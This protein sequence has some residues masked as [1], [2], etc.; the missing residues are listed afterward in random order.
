MND[1]YVLVDHNQKMIIDHIKKLP[2]NWNNINGLNLLDPE[3]LYN[4]DWAGQIGLGWVSVNDDI[5]KDYT[6]L[7]EWF[8]I[9]KSGLKA[10]VSG[11]RW[12]KE[13]DIITFKGNRLKLDDRTR[14]S[15]TL[16]K[17]GLDNTVTQINWKFIDG[18]VSLSVEDFISL[19]T[20]VINYIQSCFNEEQRLI[21][22]Y[23]SATSLED[24]LL[25]D[26]TS[27]W[28]SNTIN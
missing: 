24:L 6:S 17:I 28:P 9:S 16:Q 15:L 5:L 22:L 27:N 23:N 19:Y 3:K 12:K 1:F 25:L 21:N 8:E 11:E 26:L 7:P 10:S 14:N 13:Q 2:E 4:L 20:F 18:F